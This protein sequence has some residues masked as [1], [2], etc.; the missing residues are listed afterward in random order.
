MGFV[1]DVLV[2]EFEED[3]DVFETCIHALP[4]EG[5]HSVSGIAD[6]D[7]GGFVVVGFT[8]YADEGEMRIRFVLGLEVADSDEV[9]ADAGKVSVEV[10]VEVCGGGAG[11]AVEVVGGSEEGASEGAVDGG[12]GDEH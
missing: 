7:N 9:W 4:V 2:E 1:V 10:G 12:D 3:A 8:L 11:D 5:H 6:N